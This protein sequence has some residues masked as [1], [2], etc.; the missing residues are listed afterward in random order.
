MNIYAKILRA[1]SLNDRDAV[2]KYSRDLGFFTGYESKVMEDAHVDAVMA[3]GEMFQCDG[4]YNF[5]D[6]CVTRKIA[7]LVPTM[8]AH[9]LCPPPEEIYSLHRKLSGVFLLCSK[10]KVPINCRKILYKHLDKYDFESV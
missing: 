3:L 5:A 7:Q 9:R 2:L 8:L 10:L 1:S 4:E 6:Q